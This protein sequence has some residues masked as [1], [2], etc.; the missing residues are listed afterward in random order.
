MHT[1][2]IIP[3]IVPIEN[4]F[5]ALSVEGDDNDEATT[6]KPSKDGSKIAHAAKQNR[7]TVITTYEKVDDDD[8][9]IVMSNKTNNKREDNATNQTWPS[10]DA[11]LLT[12]SKT[13]TLVD[14]ETKIS[15]HIKKQRT[16]EKNSKG[17]I[18]PAHPMPGVQIPPK[19]PHLVMMVTKKPSTE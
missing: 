14:P 6:I 11:G 7:K 5:S 17:I 18:T 8:V 1:P 10:R 19:G 16:G 4:Y 15:L 12:T 9:T 13:T 2:T 3:I